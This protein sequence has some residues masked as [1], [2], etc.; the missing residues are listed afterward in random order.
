MSRITNDEAPTGVDDN[1]PK[2]TLFQIEY[3]PRWSKRIVEF[4][5]TM[6]FDESHEN[7]QSQVNFLEAC[8]CFQ[9]IF[10]RL[11]YLMDDGILHLVPYPIEYPNIVQE[12]HVSFTS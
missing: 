5:S 2:A 11:Y 8:N 1:L 7:L 12:A 9:L 10:G 4:L 3:V 6:Q